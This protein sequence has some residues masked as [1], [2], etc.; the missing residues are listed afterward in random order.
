ML[1]LLLILLG[2]VLIYTA[3]VREPSGG[4][5][6]YASI[7]LGGREFHLDIANTPSLRAKGLSG[8]TEIPDD[9]GM[10]FFF[11]QSGY[12]V[13]WMKGMLVPIDI[14]WIR[15]GVIVFTVERAL[16]PSS[17]TPDNALERLRPQESADTVIETRAGIAQE[18]G[19]NTG[20]TVR[21]LVP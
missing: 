16:P 11:G 4:S 20:Q 6:H 3:F 8:R 17:G 15:N 7:V 2:G 21:I 5:A 13:F 9:G 10:I 1:A 14:F 18:L 12:H 19:I